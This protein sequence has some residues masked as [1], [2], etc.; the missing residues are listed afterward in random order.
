MYQKLGILPFGPTESNTQAWLPN[1]LR[2]AEAGDTMS[3]AYQQN[4]WYI[5]QA[6]DYKYREGLRKT[7]PTWKEISDRA[8]RQ[9]WM[10][11]L[12]AA[13]LPISMQAKDPYQFFR[14]QYKQMQDVNFDTAD[15]QFYDKYG[16]SAYTFSKSL[17]KNN[18]GLKPTAESV[19]MSKYYQDLISKTG[20]E[21]AG[22][23]VGAE[24]E[25]IYSNGAF[26]YEKTHSTD[27]AT[28]QTMRGKMSARE[29]LQQANLARGWQQYN[30][31]MNRIYSELYAAGFQS[32]DDPG[33][34]QIKAEKTALVQVLSSPQT[35]DDQGN[36][37]KNE[38]Y[39]ADW[40]KAY[41]SFD[42]NYYDRAIPAL[43][44]IVNDPEIWSK[45]VNPDGSVGMR[46]DI[47]RLKT[48]LSYRDDAKRALL[49]RDNAGGSADINAAENA[50]IKQQWDSMVLELIQQDTKFGDL[51]N[52]YLSRDMG[53]DKNTVQAEADTGSLGQFQGDVNQ[54][55]DTSN[56]SI[57]DQLAQQ[58]G[59]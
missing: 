2:K 45:A 37:V 8:T 7:A 18:S 35:L 20:P 49:L 26:Y 19:Q 41:N 54:T 6:E 38:Y 55:Q 50:D 16:D 59:V 30:G 42:L 25:G 53:Y 34:E 10:K 44:Q 36:L 29:G 56:S 39:N 24:G 58:G 13:T 47:Y 32:F 12:F 28:G 23:V 5:M 15:Q 1:W 11:V 43:K 51:F 57:F 52:R 40:S 9:S 21:W 33:A 4:L 31:E 14:D 46:S 17:S 27:P 48:Y 22:L 3:G